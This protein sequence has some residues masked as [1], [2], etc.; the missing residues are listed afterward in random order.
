MVLVL[1]PQQSARR[2]LEPPRLEREQQPPLALEEQG[3]ERLVLGRLVLV[4]LVLLELVLLEPPLLESLWQQGRL[5][6]WSSTV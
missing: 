4:R 5:H 3:L 1:E 6:F 2:G